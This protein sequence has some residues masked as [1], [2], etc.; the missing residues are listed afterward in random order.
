VSPH[1]QPEP[2]VQTTENGLVMLNADPYVH[3]LVNSA[4]IF[5]AAWV[6]GRSTAITDR[7]EQRKISIEQ[8]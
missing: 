8:T 7:L 2:H 5:I 1:A 3:P 6:D 4:I